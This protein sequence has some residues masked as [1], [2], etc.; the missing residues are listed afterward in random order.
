MRPLVLFVL[1]LQAWAQPKTNYDEALSGSFVLPELLRMQDGTQIRRRSQWFDRRTELL[2]LFET[3]VYGRCVLPKPDVNARIP[4]SGTL[5]SGLGRWREVRL[6]LGATRYLDVLVVLPNSGRAPLF[7]GLNYN[8]NHAVLNDGGIRLN[9]SWMRE[10]PGA[11]DNHRALPASRGIE[12]SRWPLDAIVGAGFGVATAYYGDL[13]PDHNDGRAASVLAALDP[14]SRSTCGA[15]GVWAWGLSRILD[16]L[17]MA[18]DVDSKRVAVIGHSRLGKTALWAGAQDDRFAMI[19]SN[20]SGEGGAAL[21]RRNFGETIRD[22]NERFPYWFTPQYKEYSADPSKLP[23]DQHQ[24]LSLAVPRPLYVASAA[25]DLWADPLGEFLALTYTAP[26][27]RLFG[28]KVVETPMPPAGQSK[29]AGVTAYHV[30]PGKHD[31]NAEDW[32]EFLTFAHSL[33]PN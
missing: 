17:Q 27:Y 13:F 6:D 28:L 14:Q 31:I 26:A 3:H 11:V 10:R 22:L 23:V 21:A 30:R 12:A 24:L 4:A 15:I 32:A 33:W 18:D 5:P 16:Y 1:A 9:T 2:N 29:R 7:A 25:E 19:I 8:G 20:E